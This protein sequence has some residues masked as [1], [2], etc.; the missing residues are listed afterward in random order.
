MKT[1]RIN[2]EFETSEYT[3]T[4][5]VVFIANTICALILFIVVKF[6]ELIDRVPGWTILIV[7]LIILA[8]RFVKHNI[9]E[10]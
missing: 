5:P 10:K 8:I 2:S 4:W 9:L 7:A 1:E 3:V 6:A